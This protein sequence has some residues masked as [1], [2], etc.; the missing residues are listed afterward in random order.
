MNV[1]LLIIVI[2]ATI[3]VIVYLFGPRCR[4]V[5]KNIEQV[6]TGQ[7]TVFYQQCTKCGTVRRKVLK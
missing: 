5:W 6:S 4:H 7:K 2:V 1:L 3:G